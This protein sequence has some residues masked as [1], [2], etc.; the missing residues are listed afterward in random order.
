MLVILVYT[1]CKKCS[2]IRAV[3]VPPLLR[4]LALH[5][6]LGTDHRCLL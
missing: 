5:N 4:L 1:F 3:M 2:G 6:C